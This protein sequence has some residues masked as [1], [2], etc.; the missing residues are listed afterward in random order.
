MPELCP[1]ATPSQ[2][3]APSTLLGE[4]LGRLGRRQAGVKAATSAARAVCWAFL[5]LGIEM[6]V[7][8]WLDLPRAIRAAWLGVGVAALVVFMVQRVLRPWFQRPDLDTLALLVEKHRPE[9]CGRLI[10]AVQLARPGG[11]PPGASPALVRALVEETETLAHPLEFHSIITTGALRRYAGGAVLG[12]LTVVG[13]L[14]WGGQDARDLGRRVFLSSVPVPRKTRVVMVSGDLK[15]GRGDPVLIQARA[16]GVLP[17]EGTLLIRSL[18]RRDQR[19]VMERATDD[20]ALYSRMLENAQRDFSYVV[21]LGDGSSR[22]HHV[23]VLPRPTV[24]S[25]RCEQEFPAYTGL[26]P[27]RRAPGDLTLLAGS[28]LRLSAQASKPL[29]Q[30]QARLEGLDRVIP[31]VVASNQ[32][33]EIVG[34]IPIPAA[35]LTG[36]LIEM[37]D[38]DGMSSRD[39]VVYPVETVLDKPPTIRLLAPVRKEELVTRA[40]TVRLGFLAEDDL[41]VARV[42]LRYRVGN[43]ETAPTNSVELDLGGV[44]TARL[45]RDYPWKMASLSPPP[46]LGERVEYW[47]EAADHNN[48]TGPGL[49]ASEHQLLRVVTPEEKRADLLTR[50]GDYLGTIGDMAGDQERLSE[51]VR[52]IILEKRRQ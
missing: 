24:V 31:L 6:V 26:P 35:G 33:R 48:V 18:V 8:Y 25:L 15:V 46:A 3:L 10:S 50:A 45:E 27:T 4:K 22:T 49:G 20:P 39:P 51:N 42:W 12:F 5:W 47:L 44:N 14:L 32:P 21:R 17:R 34:A 30:A 19:F 29:R 11:L 43:L 23:T 9:F 52:A 1:I 36:F 16:G 41:G 40:A 38:S 28:T 7:D 2:E 13:V 37:V